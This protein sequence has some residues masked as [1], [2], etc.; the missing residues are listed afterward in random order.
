MSSSPTCLDPV[1][2]PLIRGETVLD[3]A[4]GYGRWGNLIQTNFWEAGLK[5]PPRVDGFDAFEPNL[6]LCRRGGKYRDV[7]LHKLPDPFEGAWDTVL[8]CEVIE[9]LPEDQAYRAVEVL[10]KAARRRVIISTPN[11]CYLRGGGDT[12]VGYNEYEAHLS[13]I[14]RGFFRK[15]GYTVVGVGYGNPHS[16][17]VRLLGLLRVPWQRAL[18]SLPLVLPSCGL[19]YVAYKDFP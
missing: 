19:L 6:E 7:W 12:I 9:H 10:E 15:R 3:V 5:A 8:A 2:I 13:Y 11:W 16:Y 14:R 18:G 1:V 4:C 17:F